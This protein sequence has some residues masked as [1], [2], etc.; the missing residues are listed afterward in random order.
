MEIYA[1]AYFVITPRGISG[2]ADKPTFFDF[3]GE[4]GQ[5]AMFLA[6]SVVKLVQNFLRRRRF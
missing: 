4:F 1:Y 6:Y 2:F 3:R 5:R